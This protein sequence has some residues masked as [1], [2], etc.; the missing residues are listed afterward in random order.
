MATVVEASGS[1]KKKRTEDAASDEK[2]Q[3][4]AGNQ[5]DRLPSGLGGTQPPNAVFSHRRLSIDEVDQGML[6]HAPDGLDID[7]PAGPPPPHHQQPD[8]KH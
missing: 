7:S 4:V 3:V 1:A 2:R 8:G 6:G 5:G